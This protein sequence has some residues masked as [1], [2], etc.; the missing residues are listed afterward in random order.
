MPGLG[1][2]RWR[3][4]GLVY[5]CI[6][7]TLDVS[8]ALRERLRSILAMIV[9]ARH[10]QVLL[11]EFTGGGQWLLLLQLL[12]HYVGDLVLRTLEES[13][14][15][16]LTLVLDGVVTALNTGGVDGEMAS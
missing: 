11:G 5:R 1:V 7:A 4:A 16:T 10:S 15:L 12:E 13:I 6:A 2:M 3:L 14:N 9:F 8:K